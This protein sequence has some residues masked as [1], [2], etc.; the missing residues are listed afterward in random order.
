M[1]TCSM[2]YYYRLGV[3]ILSIL[4]YSSLSGQQADLARMDFYPGKVVLKDG[5]VV[6][7]WV[8]FKDYRFNRRNCVLLESAGAAERSFP[9]AEVATY[10]VHGKAQYRSAR[11]NEGG[12]VEEFAEY[13]YRG[14]VSLLRSADEYFVEK[15]DVIEKLIV[16][17]DTTFTDRRTLISGIPVFR[18]QILSRMSDCPEISGAVVQLELAH[19][20]LLD[21]FQTYYNCRGIKSDWVLPQKKVLYVR[22]GISLSSSVFRPVFR[23]DRTPFRILERSKQN[24]TF[25]MGLP[26]LV[27]EFSAPSLDRRAAIRLGLGY[28]RVQYDF[29]N[30]FSEYDIVFGNRYMFD[31]SYLEIPFQATYDIIQR[32]VPIYVIGSVSFNPILSW[33]STL[34]STQTPGNTNVRTFDGAS[35]TASYGG[36]IGVKINQKHLAG[37]IQLE[38][39]RTT[40]L[41]EDRV[42]GMILNLNRVNLNV[43]V[44]LTKN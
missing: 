3:L 8:K 33:E 17:Q 10:E 28:S 6:E 43:G 37:F 1:K 27:F 2:P 12:A 11:L 30:E 44:F 41:V 20:D 22:T 39:E 23:E 32:P 7:G 18:Q 42:Y 25:D 9:A 26:R 34:E 13:L 4:L 21:I 15:G 38:Y 19:K 16:R 35:L 40:D 24:L 5:A 36:G 29:E 31:Y 14:P